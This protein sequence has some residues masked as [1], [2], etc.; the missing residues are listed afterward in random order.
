MRGG[1]VMIRIVLCWIVL[2][3][4][5]AT[6]AWGQSET[7]S[8]S[9][10]PSVYGNGEK[11]ALNYSGFSLP[12]KLFFF[13]LAGEV[14][15]DDNALSTN[16]QRI[17]DVIYRLGP[18]IA[19]RQ[20][21]KK[22]TL[23][24]DYNPEVQ[25]YRKVEGR[26]TVDQYLGFDVT[27]RPTPRFSLRV[28]DSV[29]YTTGIFQARSAGEV[30]PGLG[31]P[32]GLNDTI[33]TPLARRFE[34]IVRLDATVQKSPRTS[35]TVF[36]S[37]ALREFKAQPIDSR[38]LR[39]TRGVNGGLQFLHRL[40]QRTTFGGLYSVQ[41]SNLDQGE[42]T[43]VQGLFVTFARQ[44]SPT[45]T[46]DFYGGPQ[47]SRVRQ[48]IS[49][50]VLVPSLP[51]PL[52]I[53]GRVL[54]VRWQGA[55]GMTL[56]KQSERTAFQVSVARQISD[57][58]GVLGAVT[59]TSIGLSVQR[60]L[61]RRWNAIW[62]VGVAQN[63]A[64]GAEDFRQDSKSQSASFSLERTLTERLSA[65]LSYSF[66]RQRIPGDVPLGAD[67]NQNRVSFGLFYRFGGV[68]F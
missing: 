66:I 5:P 48:N 56:T 65:R 47:Y 51:E 3:I 8:S 14:A 23:G 54:Q 21:G 6:T 7:R 9:P 62:T 11:P 30:I 50:P 36:G 27:Y 17:G 15:Y 57:G 58:G 33:F 53:S 39:N 24:L 35:F 12:R 20:E 31:S 34:N 63:T 2:L 59:S 1:N 32:T 10:G 37:Y 25:F 67:L 28:R 26:N 52:T 60:R 68:N 44:V 46:L 49:V 22:I 16:S 61:G 42:R 55:G 4:V 38:A 43:A 18:R 45:L 29:E 13:S 40:S 64:L 41:T 19:F